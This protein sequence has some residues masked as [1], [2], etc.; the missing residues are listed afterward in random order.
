MQTLLLWFRSHRTFVRRTEC[1]GLGCKSFVFWFAYG[2]SCCTVG[3][4]K[5]LK[6]CVCVCVCGCSEIRGPFLVPCFP[7]QSAAGQ[8]IASS[9]TPFFHGCF[10]AM[11][12]SRRRSRRFSTKMLSLPERTLRMRASIVPVHFEALMKAHLLVAFFL[13]KECTPKPFPSCVFLSTI[14]ILSLSVLGDRLRFLSWVIGFLPLIYIRGTFPSCLLF[15]LELISQE[16]WKPHYLREIAAVLAETGLRF[17]SIAKKGSRRE[18][19]FD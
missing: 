6:I 15:D 5:S 19:T 2:V 4:R 13:N 1:A 16:H 18:E 14:R 11:E 9:V 3:M 12:Q 8:K 10:V 17:K 7:A